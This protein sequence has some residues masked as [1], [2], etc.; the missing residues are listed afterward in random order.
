MDIT[1]Y[2]TFIGALMAI[3]NPIGNT[4]IYIGMTNQLKPSEQH[5]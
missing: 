3:L 4:A 5:K 1:N 2:L